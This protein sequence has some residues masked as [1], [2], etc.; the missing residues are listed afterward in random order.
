MTTEVT[1]TERPK[2][3]PT[4]LY[5]IVCPRLCLWGMLVSLLNRDT[6]QQSSWHLTSKASVKVLRYT[7]APSRGWGHLLSEAL[8]N[9]PLLLVL[10]SEG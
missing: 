4:L 5:T 10:P 2:V 3:L 1:G 7:L 9:L 8:W 6:V